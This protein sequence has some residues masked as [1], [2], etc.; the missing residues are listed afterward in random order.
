VRPEMAAGIEKHVP[1]VVVR[2]IDC[3]HWTQQEAPE[4]TTGAMLE[5]L[6]AAT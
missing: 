2:R 1:N 5:F 4:Q 3:G 6:A